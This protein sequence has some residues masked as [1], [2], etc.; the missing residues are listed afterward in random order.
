MTMHVKVGGTWREVD[1]PSTKV[2]GSWQEIQEGWVKVSGTW[3]QFYAGVSDFTTITDGQEA[4]DG[5]VVQSSASGNGSLGPQAA[6]ASALSGIWVETTS[7]TGYVVVGTSASASPS[8]SLTE[9]WYDD[10]GAAQGDPGGIGA[11]SGTVVY[12]LLER[13]DSVNI[14][15]VSS[16]GTQTKLGTFTDDNQS[17]FTTLSDGT[18]Y[19]YYNDCNASVAAG[20]GSDFDS[21]DF[22]IQ[23]TFRKAGYNDVTISFK[24]SAS[25]SA[26]SFNI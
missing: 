1:P 19:G 4:A 23:I 15:T 7:T 8:P 3:Q 24:G 16:T 26:T 25:A 9:N 17:T 2:S 6:S 14:Y 20:G 10:T 22:E 13:P 11:G 18:A 5:E 21:A 12:T